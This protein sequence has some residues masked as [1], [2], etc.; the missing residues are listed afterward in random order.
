MAVY[1]T[2]DNGSLANTYDEVSS[3]QFNKESIL[4]QKLEVNLAILFLISATAGFVSVK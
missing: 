3:T 4:I 2:L 1:L